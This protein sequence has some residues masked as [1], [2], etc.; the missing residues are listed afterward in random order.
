MDA[1][2]ID[3]F[4]KGLLAAKYDSPKPIPRFHH[5]MWDLCCSDYPKVAIAAPRSHAK[6]T[7]ITHAFILAMVCFRQKSFVLLVSD[8]EGQAAEFLG[9]I[10][11]ELQGNDALRQTFGIKKL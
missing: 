6:S 2:V 3:G 1:L 9:D 4:T 11:S 7:A 8:T 5:E 10:K